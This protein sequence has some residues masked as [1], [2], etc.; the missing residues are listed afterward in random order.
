[1]G[2]KGYPWELVVYTLK[3]GYGVLCW[4]GIYGIASTGESSFG[5]KEDAVTVAKRASNI[6]TMIES[7]FKS[8]GTGGWGAGADVNESV[9]HEQLMEQY[10]KVKM[11][12]AGME[13]VRKKMRQ[14]RREQLSLIHR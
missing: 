4:T 8:G 14:K 11:R 7:Q 10:V 5:L 12:D 2:D 3:G 6:S 13:G 9:Q 1:M